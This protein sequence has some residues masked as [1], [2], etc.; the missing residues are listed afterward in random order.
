MI[1]FGPDGMLYVGLGDGGSAGDPSGNG[2]NPGT[3]LGTILR[4]DP[5][6]P[7]QGAPYAIPADNPFVGESGARGEVW[8]YGLRNPWRFS[9]DSKTGD[10]WVG[11]VGQNALEEVNIVYP[12]VNYGWN[13]MEGT[14]CFRSPSCTG[15]NLQAP[16]AEYDHSL[17]CSDHRRVC[18]PRPART[19]A[20]GGV[21][22][23]GL[24]LRPHLGSSARRRR[25]H[26]ASGVS[27][28]AVPD[29]VV[30]RGC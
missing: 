23:R 5:E 22:V 17:G 16:V 28:G 27:Q 2:Q 7:A 18:I 29:I 10:L 11:D 15:D 14:S 24:L 8:A 30:W 1:A 26:G 9:F 4:I 12:G 20:R 21:F 25:R 13:V 19:G 6:Q 3:L